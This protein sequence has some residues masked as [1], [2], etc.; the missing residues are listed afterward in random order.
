MSTAKKPRDAQL[1]LSAAQT[2]VETLHSLRFKCAVGEDCAAHF[3]GSP[4]I[5]TV[6][7]ITVL[8]PA[9]FSFSHIALANTIAIEDPKHYYLLN[10]DSG[11][12][13]FVDRAFK[14][15]KDWY[16]VTFTIVDGDLEFLIYRCPPHSLPLP[17]LSFLILSEL[18]RWATTPVL[19]PKSLGQLKPPS[20]GVVAGL[21][22]IDP[23]QGVA[24][25][26]FTTFGGWSPER[27][28]IVVKLFSS[29]ASGVSGRWKLHFTN[30]DA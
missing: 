4:E 8:R 23:P 13:T 3:Y 28:K 10:S 15:G 21:L 18:K 14:G 24:P 11:D 19:E 5:P 7:T 9:G 29:A 22:E 12:L 6:L 25:T 20:T 30:A 27:F 16:K 17:P 26:K 1:L 2:T